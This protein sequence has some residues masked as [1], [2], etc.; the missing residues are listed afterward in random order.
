MK[1][2]TTP[3]FRIAFAMYWHNEQL[4]FVFRSASKQTIIRAFRNMSDFC[5]SY[6][7][8][9]EKPAN[10]VNGKYNKNII[11]IITE[12][13]TDTLPEADWPIMIEHL[14]HKLMPCEVTYYDDI[15]KL[16]NV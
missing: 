6:N 11:V 14:L 12:P 2:K 16:F 10:F 1:N 7:I 15:N 3:V 4:C 5:R 8:T 13:R 9:V